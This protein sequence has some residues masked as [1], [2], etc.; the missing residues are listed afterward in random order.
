MAGEIAVPI[1]TVYTQMT[2]TEPQ[3]AKSI[4]ISPDGRGEEETKQRSC[5]CRRVIS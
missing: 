2:R 1:D 3:R 4:P 5:G